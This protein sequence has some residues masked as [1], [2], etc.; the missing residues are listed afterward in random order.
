MTSKD[1]LKEKVRTLI[2]NSGLKKAQIARELEIS[3][4]TV[5]GWERTGSISRENLSKLCDLLGVDVTDVYL[6]TNDLLLAPLQIKVFQL[7]RNL[8]REKYYKL[9]EV[10]RLLE[11]D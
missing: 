6:N 9:E 7:T 8:P 2:S 10:I 3:R 11:E 5:S 1:H 4:T